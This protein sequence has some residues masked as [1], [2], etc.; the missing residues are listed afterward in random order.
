MKRPRNGLDKMALD[1]ESSKL[2]AHEREAGHNC[3]SARSWSNDETI[4]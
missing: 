4:F 2:P 3:K 1:D